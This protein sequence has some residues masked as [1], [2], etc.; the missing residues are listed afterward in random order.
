MLGAP[1]GDR[2][3]LPVTLLADP[4]R[5][6]RFDVIDLGAD[7]PADSSAAAAIAADRLIGVGIGATTVGQRTVH[8]TIQAIRTAAKGTTILL[9]GAAIAD[10]R[11]A[12]RLGA[13]EYSS[14]AAIA[15]E[16]FEQMAIAPGAS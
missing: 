15:L 8:N 14:S 13:D 4:L 10:E 2:H 16:T 3:S 6:R 7:T 1:S 5:G 12:H 11:M 9:G